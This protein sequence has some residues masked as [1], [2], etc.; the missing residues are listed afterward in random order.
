VRGLG[1][2]PGAV[3]LFEDDRGLAEAKAHPT[4]LLGYERAEVTGLG[5]RLDELLGV[6]ATS[7]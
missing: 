1:V 6:L 2:A 3:D 5:H 4:V 7:V